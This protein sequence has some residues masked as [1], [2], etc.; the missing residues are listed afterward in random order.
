MVQL[1]K[2]QLYVYHLLVENLYELFILYKVGYKFS[3]IL[4]VFHSQNPNLFFVFQIFRIMRSFFLPPTSHK[5]C[6]PDLNNA[7]S[8]QH[9]SFIFWW[10]R[11]CPCVEH[12]LTLFLFL[13]SHYTSPL[14]MNSLN[15]NILIS[16]MSLAN[17]VRFNI[18]GDRG[19]Y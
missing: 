17:I 7:F 3:L 14:V 18:P 5:I 4:E 9:V 1:S 12:C 15:H 2:N 13:W 11:L 16:F 19:I 8:L 10:E 6:P